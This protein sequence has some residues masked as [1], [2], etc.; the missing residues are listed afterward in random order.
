MILRVGCIVEGYGEVEAVPRLIHRVAENHYSA[1]CYS[2]LV[3]V[4]PPPIRVRRNQVVKE[5]ELERKVEYVARQVGKPGAIFIILDSDDECP[6]EL[7][8]ALLHRAAQVRGDLPIAVVLAKREFE[9]WFL[10][11]AESLRGRGGLRNDIYSPVDPEAISDAKGWLDQR[12]EDN[13]SYSET[14]DQLV[15]TR[16]FDLEKARQTDSFDKCYR[17]IVWLLEELQK[18]NNTTNERV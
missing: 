18:A 12:M 14:T 2:E 6:A 1:N 9:A 15:L 16:Y 4:T 17:D 7:G 3:I 5:G 11:A 13:G 10:A 8:P